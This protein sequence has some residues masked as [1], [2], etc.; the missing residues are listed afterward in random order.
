MS[1]S[2]FLPAQEAELKRLYLQM[3][4]KELAS[5]LGVDVK[6]VGS[7]MKRLGLKR[8]E[9]TENKLLKKTQVNDAK[10]VSAGSVDKAT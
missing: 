5:V 2:K 1:K 9:W 7:E 10:T 3:T 4:D 6:T 8:S